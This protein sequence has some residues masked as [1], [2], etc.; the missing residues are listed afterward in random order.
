M[1]EHQL[2]ALKPELD[3][4]LDRFAPLFG[5]D[6]NQVHAR[7]FVQGL[8]HGGERRSIENIAQATSGGPV[9]SLQ[10]FI[11]TGAWSDG[12]ILRQM[13]GAVLELLADD[14]A[15]WNAAETGFPKK[16]TKSVGVRRQYSGTL[17]R[18]DNCQVAVFADYCSAKGHT[19]LDRRLFLPEEWAGDGERR[20]EAGVPAGVIFRTKPEL[21][22]AMAADAVAEG[23]PFRWVGG[24]GVY[25]D[26]PTFVQGVRQLGKRYVLDSSADARVWTGE[27]RVI[28][29]EERPR[30]R[31]GRPCTQPLVVG[32]AKRVDEVVAALPATA[33]RRLTVAEGSQ[34]PR[35][36]EY[37]ELWAWFSE[38]GLPG[39]RE[40]LLVRRSLGQ[41]PELK[42]HRSHAPAE[43][44]LSKLAQVRATRWTIEEDIQSAK[45]ECGLDEYETRGWVGWHHHTALS[46]L[47]LAFLVLQRVRLGGKSVADERAGGAC[48]V[49]S[50]AGGVGVGRRRDPA[51]VGVAP[52]AEPAGRRQPPQAAARRAA[53]ARR[54]K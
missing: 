9:R 22:L 3:R 12:A 30:P 54:E 51:V 11:S 20:E 2:L 15:A 37:A 44:P 23:V 19:F 48:P 8:L 40:R 42:Y 1:D 14:D 35:V 7:R 36:Y 52:R 29:P 41:E 6:E 53:P 27:P 38:G 49:D 43:V 18:T 10:A 45:G 50:P 33:W 24:D 34:G 26:S 4:F 21:A 17:G 13:R 5:R 31:R 32:E 16:G 25:G 28:P 39:P 47:A 46:M